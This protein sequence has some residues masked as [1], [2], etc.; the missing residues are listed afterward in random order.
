MNRYFF[1]KKFNKKI[2]K[3]W[4]G[5]QTSI[6]IDDNGTAYI[7]KIESQAN[8]DGQVNSIPY[9][10]DE[11]EIY[12]NILTPLNVNHVKVIASERKQGECKFVLEFIE[13]LTCSENP[14][15]IHLYKAALK[16][17]EMYKISR[18]NI[19]NINEVIFNKYN[20]DKKKMLNHVHEISKVFDMSDLLETINVI[21]D[22]YSRYPIHLNHFD[23]HFKNMIYSNDDICFIDW[24]TTQLSPFYS[25]L[26][27]LLRQA[28]EVGANTS[29]IIENYLKTSGLSKITEDEIL[30]GAIFWCIPAI[31]WL[32]DLQNT[33]DVPFYE[34]AEDEFKS[35]LVAFSRLKEIT[36]HTK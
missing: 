27:V 14:Q 6:L 33:D 31:H 12:E 1:N 11:L 24:A 28:D 21:Y 32:L 25:D 19:Y 4:I 15:A 34:W 36:N 30:V 5:A 20:F 2:L 17:G 18:N 35:L 22:K 13:G 8:K 26:Y 7:E 16:V 23:M 3:K 10:S 29:I 9:N